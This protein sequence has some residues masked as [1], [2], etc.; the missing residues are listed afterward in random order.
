M[1]VLFIYRYANYEPLGLMTLSSVLKKAGHQ[2]LYIDISFEKDLT[3]VVKQL[4][5][6]VIAYSVIT[7]SHNYYR[8]IN[9]ILKKDLNFF[10]VFGGPHCT[11]FPDFINE[12]G[13][14]AICRGEGESA[15]LQL[16]NALDKKE[17]I[18]TISNFWIKQ[19]GQVFK[20]EIENLCQNLDEFPFPDRDIVNFYK[21]Y[22]KMLRRDVITSRGCPYNCTYCYNNANKQIFLS[23]GKYVRQR[24][25]MNVIEELKILK[26]KYH[27]KVFHFQDDIFTLDREWTFNFCKEYLERIGIPFEVQVRV[28]MIDEEIVK[29]L[30]NAG[31]VLAM[32][33]IESGN[34]NIRKNLLKRDISDEQILHSAGLF[35]KYKIRTMTVNMVGLPDETINMAMETVKLNIEC[36]P[37]YAWNAIYQPYPMTQLSAYAIEKGYF[38]GNTDLFK[39]SFLYGKSHLKTADIRKIERLHYLFSVTVNFSWLFPLVKVL[40]KLPLTGLYRIVF[41]IHRA[42]AAIGSLRRIRISEIL[43]FEKRKYFSLKRNW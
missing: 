7:G 28:N 21:P 36:K 3:R 16:V 22:K 17:N 1:K 37:N 31:C 8:D 38:D 27:A 42:F 23:K 33:G 40:V 9:L 13:V 25:V 11:F 15:F 26:E 39:S 32:Y 43:Y 4:S 30:K 34:E 41:F 19:K 6:D 35:S 14:D 20:N 12:E 24:S 18:T 10:S 2:S 5:P 29:V